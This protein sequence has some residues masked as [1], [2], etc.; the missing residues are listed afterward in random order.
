MAVHRRR[1]RRHRAALRGRRFNTDPDYCETF[2]QDLTTGAPHGEAGVPRQGAARPRVPAR[3]RVRA[4]RPRSPDDEYPLLLTTGRTLYH[5]HTRTKTGR[6]PQLQ[7]AAPDV[8]VELSPADAARARHRARAISCASSLARGAMRRRSAS[9]HPARASSSCRSTTATGIGRRRRPARAA[10]E[11]TM[12]RWDP[13]SKQ[14]HSRS[15]GPCAQAPGRRRSKRRPRVPPRTG[16]R[17][18]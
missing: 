2:G 12:T 11:L 5:F 10:N 4:V 17:A 9:R 6:A 14:P 1:A 3:R 8:W 7:A 18:G 15:R 13:V 16:R